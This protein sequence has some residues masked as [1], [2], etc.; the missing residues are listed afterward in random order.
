MTG[1]QS[2]WCRLHRAGHS[3]TLAVGTAAEPEASTLIPNL[4]LSL[5]C[6]PYG[7]K[8]R[9]ALH[10][11]SFKRHQLHLKQ[12]NSLLNIVIHS[13]PS[14]KKTDVTSLYIFLSQAWSSKKTSLVTHDDCLPW[15]LQQALGHFMGHMIGDL[16]SPQSQARLH[17]EHRSY[18][19]A[20]LRLWGHFP[21]LWTPKWGPSWR[22]RERDGKGMW[23]PS[24]TMMWMKLSLL[25]S[26]AAWLQCRWG[27]SSYSTLS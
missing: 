7:S 14:V 4:D 5:P 21:G 2:S 22:L 6:C 26:F 17:T 20:L 16:C 12:R 3:P 24:P 23:K 13:P 8:L 1:P 15:H 9:V 18:S 19:S 27:G 10:K 25:G 11:D